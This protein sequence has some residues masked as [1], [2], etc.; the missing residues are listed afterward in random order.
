MAHRSPAKLSPDRSQDRSTIAGPDAL[1]IAA[2]R[3]EGVAFL[4]DLVGGPEAQTPQRRNRRAPALDR[5]LEKESGNQRRKE[6]PPLAAAHA[7]R[8]SR[9]GQ[10]RRVRLDGALDIP[11]DVKLAQ[12]LRNFIGMPLV[13]MHA[14]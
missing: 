10:S 6:K 11:L 2:D 9:E 1:V 4:F 3:L 7:K 14:A 8:Y 13:V 12:P 5:M